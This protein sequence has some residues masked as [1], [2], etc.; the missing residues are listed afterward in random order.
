MGVR[1]RKRENVVD[2]MKERNGW[3]EVEVAIV[4]RKAARSKRGRCSGRGSQP[5]AQTMVRTGWKDVRDRGFLSLASDKMNN[6]KD[7]M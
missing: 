5:M 1:R 4:G 3:K 2:V 6:G 7:K